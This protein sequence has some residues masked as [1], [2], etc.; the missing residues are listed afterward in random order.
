MQRNLQQ[1]DEKIA[2]LERQICNQEKFE[3]RILFLEEKATAV[4]EYRKVSAFRYGHD[5]K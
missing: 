5:P 3:Q 2:E 1:K 4:E